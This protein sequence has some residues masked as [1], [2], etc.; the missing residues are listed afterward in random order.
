MDAIELRP[1]FNSATS[2]YSSP[3][4]YANKRARLGGIKFNSLSAIYDKYL[5]SNKKEEV[6]P[7]VEPTTDVYKE[8]LDKHGLSVFKHYIKE[9]EATGAKKLRVGGIVTTASKKFSDAVAV[10]APEPIVVKTPAPAKEV[11]APVVE[12]PKVEETFSRTKLHEDTM[13]IYSE[14][15]PREVA[16]EISNRRLD[17]YLSG[18]DTNANTEDQSIDK[19]AAKIS[20]INAIKEKT[21]D[22]QAKQDELLAEEEAMD[23]ELAKAFEDADKDLLS[24]TQSLDKIIESINDTKGRLD[25][26]RR[27]L[28]RLNKVR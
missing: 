11:A 4:L 21:S 13:P 5:A 28:E 19:L 24:A 1:N 26:K 20:E 15:T 9:S 18:M 10:D 14:P 6:A 12:T 22:L 2:R 3:E 25:E 7:V 27:M 23:R 16:D 8:V 17:N